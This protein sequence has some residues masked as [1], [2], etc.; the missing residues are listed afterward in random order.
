MRNL[1]PERHA[2]V[3]DARQAALLARIPV[4][5]PASVPAG[6]GTPRYEVL[7]RRIGTFTFIAAKAEAAAAAVGRRL[8]VMPPGL[9]GSTLETSVGPAVIAVYGPSQQPSLRNRHHGFAHAWPKL[10]VDEMPLPLVVSNG[11]PTATILNYL[12]SQ[13]GVPP[14]LVAE[15][16]AIADPT[17]TLPVPIPIDRMHAETVSVGDARGL[18][19]GDNTGIGAGV[20]WQS[21]GYVYWIGGEYPID[22]ILS[23]ANSLR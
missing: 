1:A 16:R 23:I 5:V 14:Q 9:D 21:R 20:I 22:T 2:S 8:P 19:V 4:R 18:A 6:A 3:A 12:T 13:P 10:M 11:V 7:S 15:L 17:T